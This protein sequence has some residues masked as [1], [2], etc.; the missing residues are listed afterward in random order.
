LR[1]LLSPSFV[2]GTERQI[3]LQNEEVTLG[4]DVVSERAVFG[5]HIG[6]SRDGRE[7]N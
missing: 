7:G 2:G 4:V 5:F 1:L 6:R 3:C